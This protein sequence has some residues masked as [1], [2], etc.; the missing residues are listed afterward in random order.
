MYPG[1]GHKGCEYTGNAGGP[2]V[3]ETNTPAHELRDVAN[4]TTLNSTK[5]RSRVI[6]PS[7]LG[8]IPVRLPSAASLA[9]KPIGNSAI[10]L[11]QPRIRKLGSVGCVKNCE[12]GCR[13]ADRT[14]CDGGRARVGGQ[15]QLRRYRS[16][17]C[18]LH[19]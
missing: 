12:G 3:T 15:L 2:I 13:I 18:G 6:S 11:Y 9:M 14:E 7:P 5:P 10:T 16:G 17:P 4:I 1:P 19:G 8:L